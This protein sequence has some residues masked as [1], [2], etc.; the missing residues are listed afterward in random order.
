MAAGAAPG[1]PPAALRV[2]LLRL[3]QQ[4]YDRDARRPFMGGPQAWFTVTLT[5]TL[6]L[7]LTRTLT[8]SLTPALTLTLALTLAL[9][10]ALT[11]SPN[12]KPNPNPSWVG[13]SRGSP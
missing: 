13:R 12:P 7:A 1:G 9:A 11:L 4:L 2:A 10:L 8:L 5:L 3:T 6:T